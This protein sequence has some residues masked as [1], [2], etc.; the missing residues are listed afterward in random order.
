MPERLTDGG[1]AFPY[2]VVTKSDARSGAPIESTVYS[3]MSLRDHFAGL[4]M[5]AAMTTTPVRLSIKQIAEE[6]GVKSTSMT[7]RYAYEYADAM[8]AE[9]A[10]KP[11]ASTETR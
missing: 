11:T 1:P 9:R 5:A 3:G 4:A 6:D 8:L 7:A 10:R 2:E